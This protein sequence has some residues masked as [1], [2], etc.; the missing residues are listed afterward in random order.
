M[1]AST[2]PLD[3]LPSNRASLARPLKDPD[4]HANL[5]NADISIAGAM[6]LFSEIK[7][8]EQALMATV[9]NVSASS[10]SVKS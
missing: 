1:Q 10:T 6:Q 7:L 2:L 3:S 4:K 8:N 5:P 9:S